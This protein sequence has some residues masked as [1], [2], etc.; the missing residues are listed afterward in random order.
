MT[1]PDTEGRMTEEGV[2]RWRHKK[3]GSTYTEIGRATLQTANVMRLG[4]MLEMTV[5]RSEDDGSL[6]VRSAREF[7]DGRFER[8]SDAQPLAQCFDPDRE[9]RIAELIA[10]AEDTL[11]IFEM[12]DE[13]NTVGS[14]AWLSLHRIRA[15]LAAV[16]EDK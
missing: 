2:K 11:S 15:A 8:L 7:E 10:A 4:D 14:D 12:G 9:Q 6:W 13:A 16:A 3:R 5:Y 1:T